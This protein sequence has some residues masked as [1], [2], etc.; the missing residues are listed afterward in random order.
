MRESAAPRQFS[1]GFNFREPRTGYD[2]SPLS[3]FA[4]QLTRG[5][6][7]AAQDCLDPLEQLFQVLS[8]RREAP[9]L[10]LPAESAATKLGLR[11]SSAWAA[12]LRLARRMRHRCVMAFHGGIK[13]SALPKGWRTIRGA[14]ERPTYAP[15][16]HFT[17][18]KAPMSD[19]GAWLNFL[20]AS[21][22]LERW[23]PGTRD[24]P[25]AEASTPPWTS[26]PFVLGFTA[27]VTCA[28]VDAACRVAQRGYRHRCRQPGRS[29]RCS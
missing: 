19:K 23:L 25:G 2:D 9:L 12:L 28:A 16:C 15:K 5:T 26:R 3:R 11:G 14:T 18:Q 27:T 13:R 7:G 4:C 24:A 17:R 22:W 20:L 8:S 21:G 6:A 10:W 1:G 29:Q